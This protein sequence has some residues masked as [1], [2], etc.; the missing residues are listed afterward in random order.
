VSTPDRM[1]FIIGSYSVAR[2]SPACSP[3]DAAS[4]PAITFTNNLQLHKS[5]FATFSWVCNQ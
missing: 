2:I 3:V 1:L 5:S 4:A